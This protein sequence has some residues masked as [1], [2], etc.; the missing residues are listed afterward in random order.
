MPLLRIVIA[1][2]A[3]VLPFSEPGAQTF[4]RKPVKIVVPFPPGGTP[5][6]LSRILGQ[7]ASQILKQSVIVENR[8]GA[9]GNVAMEVVARSPADGYTLIMGTIGTCAINPYI[10]KKVGFDVERDFVPVM[11]V[12]SISNL[13]A[14]HPSVP[15]QSVKELV[16][17]AKAKPGELTYASS[18][19][20]SSIHLIA[21]VFQSVA[22]I[23]LRHVPYKGSALAVTALVGGETQMMFDNIPSISP[24]ALAAKVRPLAVTGTAR[25]RLFPNVP[26]M[27]EAGYPDVV[28]KPWFG[29]LAPAKTPAD[30]VTKLNEAFNEAMRD[31]TVQKRFAEIDLEPAG[32]SGADFAKL[33]RAESAK[34][35][36]VVKE[37]NIVAE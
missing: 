8:P 6:M 5:D 27:K 26:T 7:R 9:G 22:G 11:G 20:G 29:L 23:D 16:A 25:S 35:S 2:I 10:Y 19:F 30:V 13:F 24:H 3:L 17:L 32:G 36:A 21:E 28:I 34:W 33:I 14:V 4:P 15:A 12:G 1:L 18:G 31:A 37:K